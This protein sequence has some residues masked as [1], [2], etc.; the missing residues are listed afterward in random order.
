MPQCR[1]ENIKNDATLQGSQSGTWD[2]EAYLLF[3]VYLEGTL[4]DQLSTMQER[5]EFFPSITVLHIFRQVSCY[6]FDES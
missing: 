5:K 6:V 2:Q 4:F 3:P 1:T